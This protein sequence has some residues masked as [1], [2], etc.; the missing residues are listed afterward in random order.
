[1]TGPARGRAVVLVLAAL[2]VVA[3]AGCMPVP[4]TAQGRSIDSLYTWFF[5]G[6]VV[7]ALIVWVTVTLAILRRKRDE[8][9]PRQV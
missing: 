5:A 4:V 7:V 8:G 3:V 2:V 1:M 6:G 9:L